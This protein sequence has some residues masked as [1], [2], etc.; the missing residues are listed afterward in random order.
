[1]TKN[2]KKGLS[3]TELLEQLKEDLDGNDQVGLHTIS[4]SD[5]KGLLSFI[6][7]KR[8]AK[9]IVKTGLMNFHSNVH[10]TVYGFGNLEDITKTNKIKYDKFIKYNYWREVKPYNL[11]IAIPQNFK[12]ED[13]EYFMGIL[14]NYQ[15]HIVKE[16]HYEYGN[17]MDSI[18]TLGVIPKEFIYG[19]T[20]KKFDLKSHTYTH[21]LYKNK[22]HI[23]NMNEQQKS[24]FYKKIVK[25]KGITPDMLFSVE[26][27]IYSHNAFLN[28]TIDQKKA[29][30]AEKGRKGK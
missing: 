28:N 3:D 29:V 5:G 8:T 22:N 30:E 16:G 1:M 4:H 15:L 17:L 20:L 6:K 18:L 26:N 14:E 24:D 23:R 13:H 9:K 2:V 21:T 12:I 7:N 19:Y 25:E 27:E 11:I 10:F